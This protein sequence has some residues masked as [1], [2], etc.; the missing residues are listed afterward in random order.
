MVG[1]AGLDID[2]GN[3]E[4]MAQGLYEELA[5]TDPAASFGARWLQERRAG[6]AKVCRKS[7]RRLQDAPRFFAKH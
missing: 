4:I 7:L 1:D 2:T 5:R 6:E 3:D